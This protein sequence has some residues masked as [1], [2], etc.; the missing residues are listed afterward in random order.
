MAATVMGTQLFEYFD[1]FIAGF[2]VSMIAK[3]WHLTFGES[4]II[5]LTSGVG[6]IIGS[7]VWG[8]LG[9]RFGRRPALIASI[10]TFTIGT[11]LAALTP[12]GW[13]WMLALLRVVVGAGVGGGNSVGPPLIVEF[14]PTRHRVVIGGLATVTFIPIGVMLTSL[15]AATLGPVIGFRGLLLVGLLPVLLAV[16]AYWAVPESPR[17][18]L[19][20]GREREAD[21]VVNRIFGTT[22]GCGTEFKVEAAGAGPPSYVETLR[23]PGSFWAVAL[24]WFCADVI[25]FGALLW[26][27]TL[28]AQVL[29]LSPAGAAR[30]F[31]GVSLAGFLGRLAFPFIAKA[32]GRRNA[33]ALMG[34]GSA[35]LLAMTG[36]WHS[37]MFGSISAFYLFFL[38]ANLFL[39]GGWT[40]L[41]P[42]TA[43]MWPARLRARGQGVGNAFG[44][45]GKILGP[46]LLGLIAGS[47][48]LITPHATL[49]AVTPAF[50]VFAACGVVMALV[51]WLIAPETAH[52]SLEDIAL[53]PTR[54]VVE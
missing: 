19:S 28:L 46:V 42:W 14:T 8:W 29:A 54:R 52:A 2:I 33:G 37:V 16:W 30:M 20:H 53:S 21:E 36:I 4:T 17:W 15:L 13:W 47:G 9:D 10:F 5:L 41:V 11:G 38:L 6:A 50:L 12:T 45:I 7:L 35:V 44:G 34:I 22:A 32:V 40:N 31:I 49:E 24:L 1:F 23:Y 18:L 39:D 43:E 25:V 27:P 51:A 3:P 48:N 26:G